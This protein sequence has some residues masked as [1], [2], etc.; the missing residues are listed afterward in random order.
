MDAIQE[1][2][3]LIRKIARNK[4]T[5]EEVQSEINRLHEKYG[6]DAFTDQSLNKKKKPWNKGY[7]ESLVNLGT[8]GMGSEEY[9]LHLVE[10]RDY[11]KRRKIYST[12]AAILIL[13]V[14]IILVLILGHL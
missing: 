3:E 5:K 10:V 14:A 12:C 9:V 4:I 2:I 8:A 7:Y 13:V 11:L 6:E 1:R